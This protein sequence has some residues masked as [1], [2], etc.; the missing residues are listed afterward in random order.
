MQAEDEEND[1]NQIAPDNCHFTSE[2]HETINI[3]KEELSSIPPIQIS[4]IFLV[5]PSYLISGLKRLGAAEPFLG[6]LIDTGA[7]RSVIGMNQAIAYMRCCNNQR[8]E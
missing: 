3:S 5:A 7:Q 8:S 6:G 2:V 4:S 1:E